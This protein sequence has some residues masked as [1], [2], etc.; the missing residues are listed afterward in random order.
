MLQT[1]LFFFLPQKQ[2]PYQNAILK[3]MIGFMKL[4]VIYTAVEV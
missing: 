2:E 4:F 3:I 1:V